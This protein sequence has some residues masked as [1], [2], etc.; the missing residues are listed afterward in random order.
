IEPAQV[1]RD[2]ARGPLLLVAELRM[3]VDVPTPGD[4]LLFNCAPPPPDLCLQRAAIRRRLMRKRYKQCQCPSKVRKRSCMVHL[5][6][7]PWF[8]S[9]WTSSLASGGSIRCPILRQV[10]S[11][12]S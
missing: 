7:V 2:E 1:L 9:T 12:D 5:K 11:I 3:L 6:S 10:P 4:Q 8:S